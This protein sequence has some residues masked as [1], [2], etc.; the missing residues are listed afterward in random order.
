MYSVAILGALLVFLGSE[1]SF[2]HFS[3]TARRVFWY[4]LSCAL[5]LWLV[6]WLQTLEGMSMLWVF[7]S[8][9]L[10]ASV[11][12][13]EVSKARGLVILD[14][15]ACRRQ[16]AALRTPAAQGLAERVMDLVAAVTRGQGYTAGTV[17]LLG[18]LRG[19]T[20]R[21]RAGLHAA[22]AGAGA[23]EL[24]YVLT[25][26]NAPALLEVVAPETVT[27][28]VRGRVAALTTVSR[29]VLVDAFQKLGLRHRTS[30]QAAVRDVLLATR[31]LD[32]TRLKAYIDDGGD[33]HSCYKLMYNDLQGEL[34]QEVLAHVTREG[35]R[36]AA[37]F[38]RHAGP[39]APPGVVLKV[40]S[41][42]D[43]TLF[44]SGAHWP[45]GVD[46][47]Y[48]RKCFYPGALAFYA[49]LDRCFAARH[50]GALAAVAQELQLEEAYAAIYPEAALVL[51]GDNGQGDVLC[52]EVLWG[53][54]RPRAEAEQDAAAGL[55]AGDGVRWG[56]GDMRARKNFV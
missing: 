4:L 11:V 17:Q 2:V 19:T 34:Q 40:L 45:A 52:A 50:A 56:R 5:G 15:E 42:V 26:V 36:V 12:E 10:A 14:N 33:Y 25:A 55:A 51:V 6:R 23:D 43:D 28:L 13:D 41:D 1:K 29:S 47:R 32:L 24:N 20:R 44:S 8:A 3:R 38:A 31:G 22:L 16:R 39:S 54:L 46:A 30:R 18:E 7:L 37:A 53:S 27:V 9:V 21:L 49:E 48:P 35:R